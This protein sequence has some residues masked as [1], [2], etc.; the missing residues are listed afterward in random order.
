[1]VWQAPTPRE[2]P[3]L[4][5]RLAL[6][7]AEKGPSFYCEMVLHGSQQVLPAGPDRLSSAV[8]LAGEERRRIV[9]A[10]LF[11]VSAEM[12]ALARHAGRQLTQCELYEHDLPSPAGFMVF[13]EPLAT[14]TGR[15]VTVEIVAV[16][17]GV[18]RSPLKVDTGSADVEIGSDWSNGA[19]WFT[20]YSDPL[21]PLNAICGDDEDRR[22]EWRRELGPFMP[23]NELVWRLGTMEELPD[24]EH[25][26]TAWG[27]T[28]CASWLLM[29]QPLAAQTRESALRPARRRLAKVGLPVD[30]VR[31]V[32][33]R[34][35]QRRGTSRTSTAEERRRDYRVWTTGHWRRYHCGSGR[36]RI[37]RRW[38]NPHLSGPDDKP[39]RGTTEHVRIWDR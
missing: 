23:D 26:T 11:W 18:V 1:M 12:T 37:E 31:V 22:R 27:Q 21:G 4:R 2:L 32:H 33:I 6:W 29:S 14:T 19:V 20:F 24:D 13:A 10:E 3:E 25:L 5:G 7:L 35:P 17:W 34:N 16:S 15:G 30:D 36:T 9:D 38:I 28:V 8:R 39:I